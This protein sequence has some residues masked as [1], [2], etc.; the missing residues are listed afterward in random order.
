MNHYIHLGVIPSFELHSMSHLYSQDWLNLLIRQSL[1][2]IISNFVTYRRPLVVFPLVRVNFFTCGLSLFT[3]IPKLLV[4]F[5]H[6][7][8][9][10]HVLFFPVVFTR[11]V[12]AECSERYC[13][14]V[15]HKAAPDFFPHNDSKDQRHYG[16]LATSF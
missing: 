12:V 6:Y 15:I 13:R 8:S 11:C 7:D 5:V 16:K 2:L 9:L 4:N 10:V 1:I 14:S 3:T